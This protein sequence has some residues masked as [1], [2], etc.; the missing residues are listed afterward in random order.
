MRCPSCSAT[1]PPTAEWCGQCAMSFQQ[2]PAT[3]TPF[4]RPAPAPG[5]AF[6]PAAHPASGPP[7]AGWPVGD[8]VAFEAGRFPP[9]VWLRFGGRL[10]DGLVLS[11]VAFVVQLGAAMAGPTSSRWASNLLWFLIA[12]AYETLMVAVTGRT[13]G[14]MA[15]SARV[16]ADDGGPVGLGTALARGLL[17]NLFCVA[18]LPALLLGVSMERDP[19]R[20]GWHDRIAGTRV[21]RASR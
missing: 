15:I 7:G 18:L 12:V 4:A 16:V 21:V 6:G 1:N 13:L 20:R 5:M 11:G 19:R 9:G 2:Q 14:K 3:V 8:A 17:A 10:L